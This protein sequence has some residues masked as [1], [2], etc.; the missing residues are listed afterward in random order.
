MKIITKIYKKIVYFN[1]INLHLKRK[2]D[3]K[4]TNQ[5]SNFESYLSYQ[6]GT[7]QQ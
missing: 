5:I 2:L 4:G 7:L 3:P 6:K 1:M